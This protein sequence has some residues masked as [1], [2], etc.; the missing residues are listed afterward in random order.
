MRNVLSLIACYIVC[1]ASFSQ[2]NDSTRILKPYKYGW[3]LELGPC[4]GRCY[5]SNE[6][7]KYV[8]DGCFGS[9]AL[10]MNHKRHTHILRFAGISSSIKNDLPQLTE[11]NRGRNLNSSNIELLT[12]FK[13][14]KSKRLNFSPYGGIYTARFNVQEDGDILDKSRR[15]SNVTLGTVT[16]LKFN[17]E[18]KYNP[19]LSEMLDKEINYGYLKLYVGYY[20]NFFKVLDLEG[21]ELYWNISLGVNFR[22]YRV[23]EKNKP[24]K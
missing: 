5:A 8:K 22:A 9:A 24:N 6:S 18:G 11:W 12:G 21:G 14:I 10:S 7:S 4:T 20:P 23:V 15:F 16:E 17:I 2:I 1:Y 3:G 19:F 13:V